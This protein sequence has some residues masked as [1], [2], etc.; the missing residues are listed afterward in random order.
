MWTRAGALNR[1]ARGALTL[2][3]AAPALR[4]AQDVP[5]VPTPSEPAATRPADTAEAVTRAL[6]QALA[7]ETRELHLEAACR[8]GQ[9][10]SSVELYGNGVGIWD[11]K[12]QFRLGDAGL[13]SVLTA[14]LDARFP[15]M[16]DSYGGKGDPLP[17]EQAPGVTCRVALQIGGLRKH[18]TQL[19]GGRQSEELK[20]LARRI[21]DEC[22]G[23]ARTS[24]QA[25]DLEDGLRKLAAGRLAAEALH[26]LLQRR[27]Q[28]A[29]ARWLLRVD[30]S[31]AS[32]RQ[33]GPEAR[34]S[35]PRV[36]ELGRE[37]L[38]GLVRRL[39][40]AAL[41]GLPNNLYAE[42]YTN[43]TLAVLD[44]RA[45]IQA[46]RFEG[47]SATSHGAQQQRFDRL[48]AELEALRQRVATAGRPRGLR[49]G[50]GAPTP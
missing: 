21:L 47:L 7:G 3:A 26:L 39:A 46:R 27:G 16:R 24:V 4:A 40:D 44:R 10:L 33:Q 37:E 38:A 43:L 31:R 50:A 15:E 13:Q 14:L 34:R 19:Q 48:L 17:S 22:R 42:D 28:G 18:A 41:S 29:D 25:D 20:E 35:E 5:P 36:L 12:A 2:A 6:R 49:E 23:P 32:L 9:G 45:H 1:I 8:T 30:G 11:R